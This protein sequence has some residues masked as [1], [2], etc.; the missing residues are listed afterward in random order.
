MGYRGRTSMD[1]DKVYRSQFERDDFERNV[2]AHREMTAELFKDCLPGFLIL[3]AINLILAVL[4]AIFEWFANNL[5]VFVVLGAGI[6]IYLILVL[7]KWKLRKNNFLKEERER[8]ELYEK[9]MSEARD[10]YED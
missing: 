7:V 9:Y 5:W 2:N 10:L 4:F 1:S 3:F 6:G 8:K